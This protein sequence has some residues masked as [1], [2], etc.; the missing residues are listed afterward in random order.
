[1]AF[2]TTKSIYE[3]FCDTPIAHLEEYGL[4]LRQINDLEDKREII[5]VAQLQS[6]SELE[7]QGTRN[8]GEKGCIEI[9]SALK[10]YWDVLNNHK[11]EFDEELGKAKYKTVFATPFQYRYICSSCEGIQ[12]RLAADV[13]QG[14]VDCCLVCRTKQILEFEEYKANE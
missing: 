11:Q 7:L 8:I 10:K 14:K 4:T 3:E 6:V 9:K 12:I 2:V 13:K 1:M 5:T